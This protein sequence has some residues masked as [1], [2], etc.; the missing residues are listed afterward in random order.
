MRVRRAA[1]RVA[2]SLAD[3]RGN[4]A[5]I[6]ALLLLPTAGLAGMAMDW[7]RTVSARQDLQAALD[8]STLS[9]AKQYNADFTLSAA[10]RLNA[11]RRVGADLFAAQIASTPSAPSLSRLVVDFA[12]QRDG[13]MQGDASG[14]FAMTLGSLVGVQSIHIA[15]RSRVLASSSLPLE[16]ALV[17]DNTGS[18]AP[19][20]GDL[21]NAANGLVDAITDNS[22][23]NSVKISVVPFVNTVNAGNSLPLQALDR[24]ANSRHHGQWFEG[25][26]VAELNDCAQPPALPPGY[27]IRQQSGKCYIVNPAKVN[28]FDLYA[29][30]TR[31]H[32]RGCVESLPQPY[33]VLD[34]APDGANPDTLY[35]PF[36]YPDEMRASSLGDGQND[37]L[38]DSNNYWP[39]NGPNSVRHIE[40]RAVAGV[41]PLP[42]RQ[43]VE[44][45]A[46]N[47]LKYSGP[48][49]GRE[50]SGFTISPNTGCPTEIT[51][52]TSNIADI[53]R[54]IG[55]MTFWAGSGTHT[56]MG[57]AWG[58]KT[59]SPGAPFTEGAPYGQTDKVVVFMTDGI[60]EIG[61]GGH[62]QD[63][64]TGAPTQSTY[65]ARNFARANH[66]GAPTVPQFNAAVDARLLETCANVKAQG[67]TVYT[68]LFNVPDRTAHELYEQCASKPEFAYDARDTTALRA[69]FREIGESIRP[70]ALVE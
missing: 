52:L 48:N 20:I 32:W 70:L 59:L 67:I 55:R 30:M 47:L 18:M 14:E 46:F 45:R 35:T 19:Y 24:N 11:A 69:T 29:A 60:T 51:P 22:P 26:D 57:L 66:F 13:T 36:F 65:T 7:N 61:T 63:I 1:W 4:V 49:H 50:T 3:I 44:Y 41:A 8:A 21:Q 40:D 33:D 43:W 9:A 56:Q 64:A 28:V 10:Q 6:F 37:Y 27:S 16:V 23:A 15:T 2:R 31:V 58:W 42:R 17:L 5:M 68:V 38:V 54:A 39:I 12:P 53:R 34:V 62:L 25:R